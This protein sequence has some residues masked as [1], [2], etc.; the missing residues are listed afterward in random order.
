[1]LRIVIATFALLIAVSAHAQDWPEVPTS[2]YP[3]V[4]SHP[5]CNDDP[6]KALPALAERLG[7]ATVQRG[8][9]LL[10]MCDGRM[11]DFVDLLHALLDRMERDTR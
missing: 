5:P 2:G 4:V 8:A 1:M 6:F 11:Y 10:R 7:V 3:A 9:I